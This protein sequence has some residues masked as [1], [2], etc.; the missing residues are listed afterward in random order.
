MPKHPQ[1][2]IVVVTKD[3]FNS[4]LAHLL[5]PRP[6]SRSTAEFHRL[7]GG[8]AGQDERGV[9]LDDFRTVRIKGP[10]GTDLPMEVL[11]PW[12]FVLTVAIINEPRPA[13]GF[14]IEDS[15]LRK[16]NLPPPDRASC[17]PPAITVAQ[18]CLPSVVPG[19]CCHRNTVPLGTPNQKHCGCNPVAGPRA[20]ACGVELGAKPTDNPWPLPCE[21]CLTRHGSPPACG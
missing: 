19:P 21:R 10:D 5:P 11:V 6:I 13:F 17:W 2:A 20:A 9:W 18:R 8:L 4:S 12:R 3:W 15:L 14:A 7:I 1:T 16:S